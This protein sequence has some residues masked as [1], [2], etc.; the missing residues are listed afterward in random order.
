MQNNAEPV[1]FISILVAFDPNKWDFIFLIKF[2]SFIIFFSFLS[3]GCLYYRTYSSFIVSMTAFESVITIC[4]FS[5]FFCSLFCFLEWGCIIV[6]VGFLGIPL[7]AF[8]CN[9]F[10]QEIKNRK[11]LNGV[12]ATKTSYC[13]YARPAQSGLIL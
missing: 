2:L 1:S 11:T 6:V 10:I 7:F 4:R 8:I 13:S 9:S 12:T 3:S 5:F